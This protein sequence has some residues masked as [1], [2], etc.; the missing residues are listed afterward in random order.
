MTRDTRSLLVRVW[1]VT[2]VVDFL[3]ASVLGV[4]AYHT[5]VARVWRG[6]ASTV[7]GPGALQ[8]G[9]GSVAVGLLLHLA[10]AFTWTAVLVALVSRSHALRGAIRTPAGATAV[11]VLYGPLIWCVMSILVIPL[12]TKR[13]P[14]FAARWWVQVAGHVGFVALPMVATIRAGLG[15]SIRRRVA[16]AAET[17]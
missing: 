17:A 2:A 16:I 5:T 1:L 8:G 7:L 10:V 11:V 13:P 3:F 9:A 12:F 6:V 15:A 4:V 14:T